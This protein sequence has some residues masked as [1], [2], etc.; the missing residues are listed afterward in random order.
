MPDA[1]Q[2]LGRG[3]PALGPRTPAG[4]GTASPAAVS[5]TGTGSWTRL[6]TGG[7]DGAVAV[8]HEDLVWDGTHTKIRQGLEI[9]AQTLRPLIR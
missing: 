3:S 2:H 7:F 5:S 9:A 1:V 6:Y 8:E 4:G